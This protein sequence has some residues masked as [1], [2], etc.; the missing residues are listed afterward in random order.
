MPSSSRAQPPGTAKP[1]WL[2]GSLFRPH[3]LESGRL[4][5]VRLI[6]AKTPVQD[7]SK[8]WLSIYNLTSN[9]SS[10]LRVWGFVGRRVTEF[11]K[12][13]GALSLR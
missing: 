1:C 2:L 3:R 4:A 8:D 10:L 7:R 12:K 5:W 6:T 11:L 9:M 13:L